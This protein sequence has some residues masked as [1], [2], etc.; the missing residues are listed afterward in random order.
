MKLDGVELIKREDKSG[1]VVEIRNVHALSVYGKRRIVELQI[2]GSA[3]NVF[4]DMGRKPSD[5]FVRR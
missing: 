4:Q 2:P 3:G 5:D 1:I